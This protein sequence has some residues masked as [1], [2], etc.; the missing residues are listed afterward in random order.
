MA[1]AFTAIT[2]AGLESGMG[3]Q[4]CH[5]VENGTGEER[6]PKTRFS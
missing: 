2:S 4:A 1:S 3:I 5:C 6:R